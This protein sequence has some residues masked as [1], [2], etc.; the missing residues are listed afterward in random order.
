MSK[1]Y[2]VTV[3]HTEENNEKS[4]KEVL[5]LVKEAF[6]FYTNDPTHPLYHPAR[7]RGA[8]VKTLIVA[9]EPGQE[10]TEEQV[11]AEITEIENPQPD[12]RPPP[13]N[14]DEAAW[15]GGLIAQL[16]GPDDDQVVLLPADG[17]WH[18]HVCVELADRAPWKTAAAYLR[19]NDMNSH[20]TTHKA[21]W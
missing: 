10:D 14:I 17:V 3:P 20:I 5:K 19:L 2:L 13:Q 4:R 12:A 7:K 9:R 21:M 11:N 8:T 1:F 18:F 16:L 6:E 15:G